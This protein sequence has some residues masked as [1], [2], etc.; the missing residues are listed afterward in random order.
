MD[1]LEFRSDEDVY[2]PPSVTECGQLRTLTLAGGALVGFP[3]P[4]AQLS[5]GGPIAPPGGGGDD[6]GNSDGDGNGDGNGDGGGDGGSADAS[7]SEVPVTPPPAPPGPN[8]S[9]DVAGETDEGGAGSPGGVAGAAGGTPGGSSTSSGGGG[10]LPFTGFPAAVAA[11][12]GSAMTGVGLAVRRFA[13]RR[14][15]RRG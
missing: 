15:R 2:V 9:G 12:T 14:T 3:T 13:G 5:M 8:P 10:A 6:G 11:V 4:F 1:G 7:A